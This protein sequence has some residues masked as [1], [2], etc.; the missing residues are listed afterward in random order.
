LIATDGPRHLVFL[1]LGSPG[2]QDHILLSQ[3]WNFPTWRARILYL[4][5]QDV[6]SPV[7]L[8]STQFCS[9]RSRIMLLSTV[10]RQMY[11]GVRHPFGTRDQFFSFSLHYFYTVTGFLC[12][13]P[14]LTRGRVN[15]FQLLLRITSAVFLES[16]SRGTQLQVPVF[17][18]HM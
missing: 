4:F 13:A 16:E 12:G 2:A 7:M 8:P 11:L 6:C 14:S 9:C 5:S 15:S 1:V 18:S 10:R 3:F 17:I